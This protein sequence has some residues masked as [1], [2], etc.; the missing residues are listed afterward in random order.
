MEL[1]PNRKPGAWSFSTP[2][3]MTAA[4]FETLHECDPHSGG[5]PYERYKLKIR[6]GDRDVWHAVDRQYQFGCPVY[7]A[8]KIIIQLQAGLP[9]PPPPPPQA[10]WDHK[11]R[12]VC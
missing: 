7:F 9:E 10:D 8:L 2:V 12:R 1:W 5:C 11:G 6:I 4:E 3:R